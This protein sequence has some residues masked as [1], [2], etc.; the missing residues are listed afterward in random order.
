MQLSAIEFY[1]AAPHYLYGHHAVFKYAL[2]E[3]FKRDP[4]PTMVLMYPGKASWGSLPTVKAIRPDFTYV[5]LDF[6]GQLGDFDHPE[7]W[8]KAVVDY[9]KS[10]GV[11]P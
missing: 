1:T 2:A 7:E 8:S 5:T 3:G 9:L 6:K 11:S 4:V 10:Q